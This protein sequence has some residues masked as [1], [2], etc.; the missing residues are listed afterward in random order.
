MDSLGNLF[1][2]DENNKLYKLTPTESTYSVESIRFSF[3]IVDITYDFCTGKAYAIIK[4]DEPAPPEDNQNTE[5]DDPQDT[6]DLD[7][8]DT[9]PTMVTVTK[10]VD[11]NTYGLVTNYTLLEAQN[12]AEFASQP[13]KN[14]C[15]SILTMEG[16][17]PLYNYQSLK[18]T[19]TLS[20]ANKKVILLDECPK[21][22]ATYTRSRPEFSSIVA[23]VC[24]AK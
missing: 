9:L 4:V 16:N 12:Y 22:L 17:T 7:P 23:H 15:V 2:L 8:T 6:P 3:D 14:Q 20:E 19:K 10:I 5:N 1:V 24:L 18:T 21:H 13:A 11:L